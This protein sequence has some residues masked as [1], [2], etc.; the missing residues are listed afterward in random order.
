MFQLTYLWYILNERFNSVAC[1]IGTSLD[2]MVLLYNNS[3]LKANSNYTRIHLRSIQWNKSIASAS[4]QW[5]TCV[6]LGEVNNYWYKRICAIK[7]SAF[8]DCIWCNLISRHSFC[9]LSKQ[10]RQLNKPY[11]HRT[12]HRDR[13]WRKEKST[14]P[15]NLMRM[16]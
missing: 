7:T 10:I 13:G 1:S 8:H 15:L 3:L 6:L 9:H 12:E 4:M 11:S 2:F 5:K 14:F 16:Q